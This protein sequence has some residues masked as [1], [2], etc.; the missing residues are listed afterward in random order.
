MLYRILV[1]IPFVFIIV[2]TMLN[3]DY[4][5]VL[6]TTKIGIIIDFFILLIYVIYIRTI[7]KITKVEKV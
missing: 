7:K 5:K 1:V 6:I 4:F 2:I 3:K